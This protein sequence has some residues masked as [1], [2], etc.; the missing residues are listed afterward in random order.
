MSFPSNC[1]LPA[2]GR[3]SKV[4]RRAVVVFP[5]PL[6]PTSPSISPLRTQN[7]TL[8]TACTDPASFLPRSLSKNDL[9]RGKCFFNATT[10]SNASSF[11]CTR[12]T[13]LLPPKT[14]YEVASLDFYE[15]WFFSAT[16]FHHMFTQWIESATRYGIQE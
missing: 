9:S 11:M 2:S 3:S 1:T 13:N 12:S 4:I 10:S 14:G 7:D 5:D 8:S 15:S 16:D 6:S